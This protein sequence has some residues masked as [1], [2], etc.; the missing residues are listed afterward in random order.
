[1]IRYEFFNT[2]GAQCLARICRANLRSDNKLMVEPRLCLSPQSESLAARKSR[3][4]QAIKFLI[5][6][7]R[8]LLQSSCMPSPATNFDY[9]P[10]FIS[11]S[12]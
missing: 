6:I 3:Q 7:G 4:S 12:F 9:S 10:L 11:S 1:M 5:N 8:H 2:P